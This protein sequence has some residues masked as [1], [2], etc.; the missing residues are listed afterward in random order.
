ML[1]REVGASSHRLPEWAALTN[2]SLRPDTYTCSCSPA[3][4]KRLDP[5][6]E[7]ACF[8]SYQFNSSLSI[9]RLNAARG[10]CRQ[11]NRLSLLIRAHQASRTPTRLTANTKPTHVALAHQTQKECVWVCKLL[12]IPSRPVCWVI[13]WLELLQFICAVNMATVFSLGDRISRCV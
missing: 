13:F 3:K 4:K 12:L 1:M 9:T 8:H 6:R 7:R 11:R 10:F 2:L 5:F